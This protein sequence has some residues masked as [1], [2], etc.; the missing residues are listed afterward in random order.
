[1]SALLAHRVPAASSLQL[2]EEGFSDF[3]AV[4]AS[5]VARQAGIGLGGRVPDTRAAL[6]AE[7]EKTKRDVSGVPRPPCARYL[8][9][10][11]L[12]PLRDHALPV[13]AT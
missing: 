1:M 7:L 9:T 8:T 4:L 11:S 13:R 2:E 5:V 10:P 6:E 3:T 12:C